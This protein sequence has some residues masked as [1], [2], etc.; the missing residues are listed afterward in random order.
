MQNFTT[1]ECLKYTQ[2]SEVNFSTKILQVT[3]F[4]LAYRLFHEDF[5]SINGKLIFLYLLAELFCKKFS[6]L[7]RIIAVTVGNIM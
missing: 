3:L 7:I 6:L 1:Q 2:N 4:V 5:S